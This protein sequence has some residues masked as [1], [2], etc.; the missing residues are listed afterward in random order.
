MR[1]DDLQAYRRDGGNNEEVERRAGDALHLPVVYDEALPHRLRGELQEDPADHA[2]GEKRKRVEHLPPR[3]P[4][5]LEEPHPDR[6]RDA[7][8][9]EVPGERVDGVAHHRLESGCRTRAP[10]VD[11]EPLAHPPPLERDD[12]AHDSLPVRPVY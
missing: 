10:R 5:E 6:D 12:L 3:Q 1:G 11:A 8:D 4:Q 2:E 9:R 7:D